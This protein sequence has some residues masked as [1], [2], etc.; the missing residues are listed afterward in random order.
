MRDE[1]NQEFF[2][3]T[4][5][6]AKR[7]AVVGPVVSSASARKNATELKGCDHSLRAQ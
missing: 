5:S 4:L 3:I 6:V 7:S 1:V 2:S